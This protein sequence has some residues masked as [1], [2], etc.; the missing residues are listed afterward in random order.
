MDRPS[1]A[2]AATQPRA[3]TEIDHSDYTGRQNDL[4]A[5]GV[6]A[7]SPSATPRGER[8]NS[9]PMRRVLASNG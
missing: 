1:V 2:A 8:R 6:I 4:M 7:A 9:I 3:I 5:D